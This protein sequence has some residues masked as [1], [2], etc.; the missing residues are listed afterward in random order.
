MQGVEFEYRQP[1]SKGYR[2]YMLIIKA[3]NVR[4]LFFAAKPNR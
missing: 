2:V 3:L 1:D 4:F